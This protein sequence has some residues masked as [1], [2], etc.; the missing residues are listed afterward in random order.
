MFR[1]TKQYL[2]LMPR[3]LSPPALIAATLAILALAMPSIAAAGT[4]P[5]YQCASSDENVAPGWSVYSFNSDASTVL[6]NSCSG[7]GSLGDYVFSHG[8]PGAVE[9]NGASGSQ[10]GLQVD[11]PGSAPDVSIKAITAVVQVSSVTGDDAFLGF[12]SAGQQLPGASEIYNGGSGYSGNDSW[13]TLPQGAR[14]FEVYVNC[15]T[16]DSST[17]CYFAD[18]VAVPALS[19]MVFTLVDETP[20][21]LSGVS[22]PLAEAA[23][24][25]SAVSGSQTIGFTGKDADSGVLSA[26]LKLTPQGAATPYSHTFEFSAQCTY[27]S[28][29]ACPL[30]QSVGGFSVPTA[31]LKDGSYAVNLSVTDAAGNVTNDPLGTITTHN[32]PSISSPPLLSGSPVVGQTLDAT[33]GSTSSNPEAGM[34]TDSGQWLSCDSSAA[35]CVPIV[36]ATGTSYNVTQADG[37]HA[38]R[39]EQTVVNNAGSANA[40]SAPLGPVTPSAAEKEQAEKEK[41][42]KEKIEK[43]KIEKEKGGSGGTTGA[44]G[45]SGSDGQAGSD[46][47]SGTG[48]VT[49]NLPGSNLGSIPLGSTAKWALSLHV[50]PLRVH[51][52]TKIKLSG[53]VS[54]SPRPTEG[55][56]IYLQARSVGTKWRDSGRSRHRVSVFGKWVTFQ[57]F[58]AKAGGTF[59]SSYTFRLGG[60]HTYQF[61]AVAPAEGQY[62]N[63]TG[64]SKTITV[65]EI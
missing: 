32:A 31:T 10:V 27:D 46:S 61:Q 48:G 45:T 63:P 17:N 23:A 20:P 15:S 49:I 53:L 24:H 4:Y 62:R 26:T 47:S 8:Q 40:Q 6:S 64:T 18:S 65:K 29:N 13:L 54:T 50:N 41:A 2:G 21:G 22:G 25:S 16:D 9:E 59:S 37:G 35:N 38:I 58:R 11:V 34:L 33:A 44:G 55:K 39:Y 57:A 28:W 30:Q 52:G 5:M 3:R 51:R 36:G 14:D 1:V 42:E 43:E 19:N 7:G 12:A 60:D 56:L